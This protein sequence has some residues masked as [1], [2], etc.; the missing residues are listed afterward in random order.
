MESSG[1]PGQIQLTSRA[2][3]VLA[4]DFVLRSRGTMDVKGKGPME[5]FVLEGARH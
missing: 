4:T 1:L 3:D 5:I 2:A